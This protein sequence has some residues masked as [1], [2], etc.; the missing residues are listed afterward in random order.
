MS[1]FEPVVEHIWMVL[2][3]SQMSQKGIAEK[4]GLSESV[5][6]KFLSKKT[7]PA[8]TTL[9]KLA[10]AAG[11]NFVSVVERC[12]CNDAPTTFSVI[13]SLGEF[14][15]LMD[16][17]A[18]QSESDRRSIQVLLRHSSIDELLEAHEKQQ[19]ANR[20]RGHAIGFVLEMF[21]DFP[22]STTYWAGWDFDLFDDPRIAGSCSRL[23]ESNGEVYAIYFTRD[24]GRGDEPQFAAKCKEL[25]F[26][27]LVNDEDSL[28]KSFIANVEVKAEY[29][30][31]PGQ[32]SGV[33]ESA[34][35]IAADLN[36]FKKVAQLERT[37]VACAGE[38]GNHGVKARLLESL[39]RDLGQLNQSYERHDIIAHTP[40]GFVTAYCS[41]LE[42]EKG[43]VY[44]TSLLTQGYNENIELMRKEAFE[45]G[46]RYSLEKRL[47]QGRATQIIYLCDCAFD[48]LN[49]WQ[50]SV[51][52]RY[53]SK[54]RAS[55][56]TVYYL[57]SDKIPPPLFT[58]N[59]AGTNGLV[60]SINGAEVIDN[61]E[62][63]AG[64]RAAE[65]KRKFEQLLATAIRI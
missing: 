60:E 45:Y 19:I 57:Q 46:A 9:A 38:A 41:L 16:Y 7:S 56:L 18:G 4:S 6:S 24:G 14:A 63:V 37:R 42:E 10:R 25:G 20:K 27:G 55:P 21:A 17:A 5:V 33:L 62:Q 43:E 39:K 29:F 49:G 65:L 36:L 8:V 32:E 31:Y 34:P 15:R 61:F 59:R 1:D 64:A 40:P 13:V 44:I 12:G 2:R 35:R 48:E 47:D 26:I 58:V 51:L 23:A 53:A 28:P 11:L 30:A 54:H 52:N 22:G 3:N 50:L